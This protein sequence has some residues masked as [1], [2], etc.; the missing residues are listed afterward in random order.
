MSRCASGVHH[1]P[2]VL[3]SFAQFEREVIEERVRDQDRG[4]EA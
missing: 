3:L 1:G 4:I 2:Q